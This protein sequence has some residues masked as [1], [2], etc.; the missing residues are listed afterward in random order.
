MKQTTMNRYLLKNLPSSIPYG[1][2]KIAGDGFQS[3]LVM[4]I[5]NPLE[6]AFIVFSS[7]PWHNSDECMFGCFFDN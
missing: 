1:G 6:N 2:F 4:V 5:F 7:F 3:K